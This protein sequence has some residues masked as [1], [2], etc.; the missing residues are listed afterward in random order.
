MSHVKPHFNAGGGCRCKCYKCVGIRFS[1]GSTSVGISQ[2]CICKKCSQDCPVDKLQAV[3]VDKCGPLMS[4]IT[5]G[6]L[7]TH[8]EVKILE[9]REKK[10]QDKLRIALP[11]GCSTNVG[12]RNEC[13]HGRLFD[14]PIGTL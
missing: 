10:K 7:P 5:A 6:E 11:C 2:V 9:D 1:V 14:D 13:M 3:F 8:D 4:G 12:T